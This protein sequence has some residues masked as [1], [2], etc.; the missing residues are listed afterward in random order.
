LRIRHFFFVG[1]SGKNQKEAKMKITA[2]YERLSSG[3]EGRDGDSNSIKN[4]SLNPMQ[5]RRDLPTF[6]TT[7]TTTNQAG[8]STVPVMFK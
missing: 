8:F 3:D 1:S 7:R 4:H 5:R 2:L 6:A